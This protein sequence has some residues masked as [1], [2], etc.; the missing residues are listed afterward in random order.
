MNCSTPYQPSA[1]RERESCKRPKRHHMLSSLLVCA[2]VGLYDCP[3]LEALPG[4]SSL[5]KG[6]RTS[7][8]GVRASL[9]ERFTRPALPL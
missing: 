4:A 5:P 6:V 7:C 1:R 8:P 9:F 2:Y 3:L